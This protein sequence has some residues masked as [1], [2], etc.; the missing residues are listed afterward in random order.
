MCTERGRNSG[1]LLSLRW[2][3]FN[4]R[5]R[6]QDLFLLC[7]LAFVLVTASQRAR[8]LLWSKCLRFVV[9]FL[10]DRR[11]VLVSSLFLSFFQALQS[12]VQKWA[13]GQKRGHLQQEIPKTSLLDRIQEPS[14]KQTLQT[15]Q[16]HRRKR[17]HRHRLQSS[18]ISSR[19]LMTRLQDDNALKNV[20]VLWSVSWT[21]VLHAFFFCFFSLSFFGYMHDTHGLLMVA[22]Q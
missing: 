14:S 18:Q 21:C 7:S 12:H 8:R 6:Y 3:V 11:H 4:A 1:F 10:L 19:S 9:Y 16:N 5:K 20:L 2:A 13:M 17:A 15:A 22:M